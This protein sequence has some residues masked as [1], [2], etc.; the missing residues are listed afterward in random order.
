MSLLTIP[1]DIIESN[2]PGESAT[3]Q[4]SEKQ[5]RRKRGE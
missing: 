1:V 3:N 5:E 4:R 2:V